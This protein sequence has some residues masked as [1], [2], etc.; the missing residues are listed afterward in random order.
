MS[1]GGVLSLVIE[2]AWPVFLGLGDKSG[3]ILFPTWP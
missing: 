1:F 2:H 3:N